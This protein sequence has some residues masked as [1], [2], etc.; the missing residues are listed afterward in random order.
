M[1]WLYKVNLNTAWDP[2]LFY[3]E[4]SFF[5]FAVEVQEEGMSGVQFFFTLLFSILGLGVLAVVGMVVYGRWKE[6]RRKR[7]Y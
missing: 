7:F 1:K 4:S 5:C 6:N 3:N 2:D